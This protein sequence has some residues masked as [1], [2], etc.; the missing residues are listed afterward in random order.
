MS[1]VLKHSHFETLLASIA[2]PRT[3]PPPSHASRL[4]K[5]LVCAFTENWKNRWKMEQRFRFGAEKYTFFPPT[6]LFQP[7]SDHN[8]LLLIQAYLSNP[9]PPP[10]Y[11]GVESISEQPPVKHF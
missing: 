7:H 8:L 6:R 11:S 4:L 3:P 2:L 5:L 1:I 9:Q 10:S